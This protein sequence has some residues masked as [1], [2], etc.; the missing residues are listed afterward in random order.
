MWLPICNSLV[1][2]AGNHPVFK[3]GMRGHLHE[4]EQ[5][6][7]RHAH[8]HDLPC[9]VCRY[10]HMKSKLIGFDKSG[11]WPLGK[12]PALATNASHFRGW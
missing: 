5:K 9:I 6:T 2:K 4:S 7:D 1:I 11:A 3:P 10:L 8:M 12:L